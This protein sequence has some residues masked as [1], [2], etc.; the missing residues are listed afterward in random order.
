M[1]DFDIADIGTMLS[2]EGVAF[3]IPNLRT[4]AP[5]MID[6]KTALSITLLGRNSTMFRETMEA[7]RRDRDAL[8]SAGKVVGRDLIYDEDT[9]LL[10]AATVKWNFTRYK[11]AE[12]PCNARNIRAFW[13][14]RFFDYV[15]IAALQF[16][17]GDVNFL[18][19]S[20]KLSSDTPGT[21]SGSTSRSPEMAEQSATP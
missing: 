19:E 2:D 20:S 4:G 17:L 1:V 16:V 10:C 14:D 8:Q 15:R 13:T 7:V 6:E 3:Q 12:F 5:Y 21:N 18:P 11:G 9:R